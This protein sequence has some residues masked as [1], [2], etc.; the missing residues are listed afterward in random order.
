MCQWFWRRARGSRQHHYTALLPQVARECQAL[1]DACE[2]LVADRCGVAL[3][4]MVAR[5]GVE[6]GAGASSKAACS[7]LHPSLPVECA[8]RTACPAEP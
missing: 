1:T 6:C 4:H 3:G 7:V 8:L 5:S 2:F